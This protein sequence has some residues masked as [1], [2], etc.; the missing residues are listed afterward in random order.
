MVFVV[1]ESERP[2]TGA[3]VWRLAMHWRVAVDRAVAPFG[4]THAQYS[5][6]A[7]LRG[8][9]RHGESPSQRRL[10]D[11]T[12]LEPIYMS[13]LVRALEGN[14]LLDRTPDPAD[15][16]AVRLTLTDRG[17]EVIDQAIAVVRRLHAQLT[18]PLGGPDSDETKAL[19]HGL[20]VLLDASLPTSVANVASPSPD[21]GDTP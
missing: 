17:V 18:E 20:Q 7:S 8:L 19:G 14:G 4:L 12:G 16:R 10:A 21:T 15:A 9:S 5:A 11:Y 2:T 6:L 1:A 13:K 3:L